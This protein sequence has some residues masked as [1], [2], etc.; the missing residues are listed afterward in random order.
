M[1]TL[2]PPSRYPHEL[3]T[4]TV[5]ITFLLWYLSICLRLELL[6]LQLE[7]SHVIYCYS[8]GMASVSHLSFLDNNIEL[9]DSVKLEPKKSTKREHPTLSL[10]QSELFSKSLEWIWEGCHLFFVMAEVLTV[11][12]YHETTLLG[13]KLY[14]VLLYRCC[15]T[16]SIRKIK[17]ISFRS[18][19]EGIWPQVIAQPVDPPF[20]KDHPRHFK[21]LCRLNSKTS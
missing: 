13:F 12:S 20:I 16:T 4:L 21:C 15:L 6:Y 7:I 9:R 10:A 11:E 14:A 18:L 19:W 8:S 1:D 2:L 17:R 5:D 3:M